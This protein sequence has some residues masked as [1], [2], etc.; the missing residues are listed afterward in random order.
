MAIAINSF[1]NRD[2]FLLVVVS[3][4][5]KTRRSSYLFALS[6]YVLFAYNLSF[7]FSVCL[8]LRPPSHFPSLLLSLSL[9]LTPSF[10]LLFEAVKRDLYGITRTPICLVVNQLPSTDSS[11]FEI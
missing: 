3:S 6:F 9:S 7:P 10:P 4:V 2:V 8:V 11:A 1:D 5:I